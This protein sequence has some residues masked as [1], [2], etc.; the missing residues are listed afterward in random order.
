MGFYEELSKYYDIVFPFDENK[1]NFMKKRVKG[2]KILDVAAGTGNYSVAL[3]KLGYSVTAIDLDQEMIE[4]IHRKSRDEGVKVEAHQLDMRDID[5]LNENEFNLI[6]CIGNSLAHLNGTA[7]IKDVIKK[8]YNL[9]T[10]GG[11]II[12]QTVNYDRVLKYDVKE[13]PLIDRKKSGVKFI[14]NYELE[15]GKILF[16]TK[17]I[18]NNDK[19]YENC[20]KLYP[21]TSRELTYI[22]NDCGFKKVDIYGDFN[23]GEFSINSFPMIAVAYK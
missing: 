9:L 11:S 12:I 23:E 4:K 16:K 6:F 18:I 17:L 8:M 21:L 10:D 15:N 20:I 7:E 13:L 2:R 14:R 5:R 3:A 22:L 19:I 1:L